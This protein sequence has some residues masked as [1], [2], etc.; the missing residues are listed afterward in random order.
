M[1]KPSAKLDTPTKIDRS[2]ELK[3]LFHELYGAWSKRNRAGLDELA[4]RCGV[5]PSYLAHIR[6]Y[7]RIPGKPVLLLLALNFELRDPMQLFRAAG[8][9]EPWPFDPGVGLGKRNPEEDSFFTLRFDL[10][11]FATVIRDV[12]RTELKPRN[13]RDVLAG[14][15]LR[16][17]MNP[18]QQWLF[19]PGEAPDSAAFFPHFC[20]MLQASLQCK[21][22]TQVVDFPDYVGELLSGRIDIYGPMMSAPGFAHNIPFTIPLHRMGVSALMR[23]RPTTGME[24]LPPPSD[25]DDIMRGKYIIAVVRNS[26]PHLLAN[27]RFNRSDSSLVICESDDE[28][29]DRVMLKG[30]KKPAHLFLCNSVMAHQVR[31]EHPRELELLFAAQDTFLD[32]ADNSLAVRPDWPELVAILNDSLRFLFGSGGLASQLNRTIIK[33]VPGLLEVPAAVEEKSRVW[34]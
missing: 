15:A 1:K 24:E 8:I 22:E 14:R 32:L 28:A 11:R 9:N 27:T 7:G 34:I 16:V 18:T 10:D 17:G 12:V 13:F 5:T 20:E 33:R 31:S 30:V 23:R 19:E 4:K 25:V 29:I 6:R 26:R 3:I 2:R 21:I